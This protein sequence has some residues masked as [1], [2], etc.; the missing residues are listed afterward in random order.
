MTADPIPDINATIQA[1]VNARIEAEVFAALAGDETIGTYVAA[2]LRQNIAVKDP[3]RYTT[4]NVPFLNHVLREAIQE[5]TKEA[6]RKLI[7][8]ELPTIETEVRKALRRAVPE[9]ASTLATQ[10]ATAATKPY[11]VSVD[12]TLKMPNSST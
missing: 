8:E 7:A 3:D 10:L 2:A 9:I 6:T 1:A 4:R 5:A 11:G 12:L